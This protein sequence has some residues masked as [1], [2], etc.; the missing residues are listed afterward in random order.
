M[1]SVQELPA[2]RGKCRVQSTVR[3]IRNP[4]QADKRVTHSTVMSI[5]GNLQCYDSWTRFLVKSKCV[6]NLIVT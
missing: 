3:Q 1:Q 6:K 5:R 4:G 2:A